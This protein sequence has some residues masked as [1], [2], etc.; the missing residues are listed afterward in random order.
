MSAGDWE[1][2]DSGPEERPEA[3]QAT[4]CE[5]LLRSFLDAADSQVAV[6]AAVVSAEA[7]PA[8]LVAAEAARAAGEDS[9]EEGGA[10][11]GAV[12][13]H[14]EPDNVAVP[15]GS[16]SVLPDG[17]PAADRVQDGP[18]AGEQ[19]GVPS[20]VE[21]V[22]P[23]VPRE[24]WV[25]MLD[26]GGWDASVSGLMR[27]LRLHRVLGLQGRDSEEASQWVD[28]RRL[29]LNACLRETDRISA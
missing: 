11:E 8:G 12:A 4:S 6:S 21:V 10:E 2:L 17:S 23:A 16:G 15:V 5:L 24:L 29:S 3:P 28:F 27:C 9:M 22:R 18:P 7:V 1:L 14:L 26:V 19:E 20:A 13:G 25:H